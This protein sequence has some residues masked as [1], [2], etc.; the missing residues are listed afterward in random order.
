M[1][2]SGRR[3]LHSIIVSGFR[4][5]GR[6]LANLNPSESTPEEL[7]ACCK[8]LAIMVA[9]NLDPVS[10]RVAIVESSLEASS[11]GGHW[12]IS[13]L[14]KVDVAHILEVVTAVG[15]THEPATRAAGPPHSSVQFCAA[16][17]RFWGSYHG[18]GY[19]SFSGGASDTA[20]PGL[21]HIFLISPD[22]IPSPEAAP[23]GIQVHYVNPTP[24]PCRLQ[25]G[26]GSGWQLHLPLPLIT[27]GEIPSEYEDPAAWLA[28]VIQ[29]AKLGVLPGNLKDVSV[30]IFAGANCTVETVL[31][32]TE[33]DYLN[34]GQT[35]RLLVKVRRGSTPDTRT[36]MADSPGVL[37]YGVSSQ[38]ALNELDILLGEA[39]E[40]LVHVE[41]RYEHTLLPP[42]TT[43]SIQETGTAKK[44]TADLT[45][46]PI[47]A[48]K[49]LDDPHS[50]VAFQIRL[51][52]F[53][54]SSQHPQQ[55]L[56]VLEIIYGHAYVAEAGTCKPPLLKRMLEELHRRA[57]IIDGAPLHN[58]LNLSND[59][60]TTILSSVGP[61][62]SQAQRLHRISET[63]ISD[64]VATSPVVRPFS[65]P[66][67]HQSPS[68][69][70]TMSTAS[71]TSTGK[72]ST[73]QARQIWAHMRRASKGYPLD[74]TTSPPSS[75]SSPDLSS[76]PY[77]RTQP[78]SPPPTDPNRPQSPQALPA[79]AKRTSSSSSVDSVLTSTTIKHRSRP[80]SVA[81]EDA[82]ARESNG[83]DNGAADNNETFV[84]M[85]AL[86]SD[87]ARQAIRNKRSI[88]ADTLKSF[89]LGGY[90]DVGVVAPWL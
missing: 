28:K 62:I 60:A 54:A 43:L 47:S 55:A 31:G 80:V 86:I 23:D 4:Q 40:E 59:T 63:G 26:S 34:P 18:P 74:S 15:G 9:S 78:I 77:P 3:D 48:R 65:Y 21:G 87:M 13:S 16:T 83:V 66:G 52:E 70:V 24:L 68:P 58:D 35:I 25:S 64:V 38:E 5:L 14:R 41:V 85:A 49:S 69:N 72:G 27:E 11:N 56:A 17:L 75:L 8:A 30:S 1:Q 57:S 42:G 73:D 50:A 89:A 19:R 12:V 61:D 71:P 82:G 29:S 84:S 7:V 79:Q 37:E 33:W 88:G 39:V 76:P 46:S 45:W 32:Q 81:D 10:D 22:R 53:I 44:H 67:L 90:Q 36:P 51:I 6:N 2:A 20:R